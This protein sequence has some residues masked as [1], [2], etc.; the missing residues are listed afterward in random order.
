VKKAAVR[1]GLIVISALAFLVTPHFFLAEASPAPSD[2]P[3]RAVAESDVLPLG[4]TAYPSTEAAA[5]VALDDDTAGPRA[6]FQL[7]TPESGS[8][9]FFSSDAGASSKHRYLPVL[10]SL[11]VPGTGEI[12]TGYYWRGA[13]LLAAEITAWTGYAY[14]HDQ[15]MEGRAEYERFADEHWDYDK[16]IFDHPATQ[17]LPEEDRTFEALDSIGQN[18]WT[19]QWPGYH[20]YFPKEEEKQNYYE[21]IGK[22]DWFI[23]GWGDWDP[24]ADPWAH[25]T[26]LR[27]EYRAMR[28][29]SNDQFDKA[30]DFIYLSI[31][32][33]VVSLVEMVMITR[34]DSEKPPESTGQGF[35]LRAHATGIASGEI[36]LVYRFR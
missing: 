14:Y 4:L 16:W 28:N 26:D 34:R 5:V 36:A 1:R 2:A 9:R 20:T 32:A 6:S 25:D 33:R 30:D 19:D 15:G 17:D 22:Y 35:S 3:P 7:S 29:E 11:L 18:E 24:N 13:V 31:A 27:T 12:Y 8:S 10:M 23:S 21:T